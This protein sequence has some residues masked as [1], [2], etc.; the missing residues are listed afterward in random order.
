MLKTIM[1][2]LAFF[3]PLSPICFCGYSSL[4]IPHTFSTWSLPRTKAGISEPSWLVTKIVRPEASS[5]K[6]VLKEMASW[7]CV[8][9][10]RGTHYPEANSAGHCGQVSK[11]LTKSQFCSLVGGEEGPPPCI[12]FPSSLFFWYNFPEVTYSFTAIVLM[13]TS[14]ELGHRGTGIVQMQRKIGPKGFIH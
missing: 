14:H 4:S 1:F 12:N 11:M 13:K 2:V 3:F 10:H 9:Q 5:S 7:Q 8:W 6:P